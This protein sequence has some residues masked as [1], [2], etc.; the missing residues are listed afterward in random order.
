MIRRLFTLLSALSLLLCVGTCVLWARAWFQPQPPD[1]EVRWGDASKSSRWTVGWIVGFDNYLF[2]E[3][4]SPFRPLPPERPHE[5]V[6]Y[7]SISKW[8][9][10]G[11]YYS[12]D[13]V[14]RVRRHTPTSETFAERSQVWIAAVWPASLTAV[15]PILSLFRF[16]RRR[17]HRTPGACT[18][19]GYDLRA[20]PDR[21]PECGA[22]PPIGKVK[23]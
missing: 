19:C 13:Q 21:C 16:A 4:Y 23:A 22:V 9:R 20:T 3:R 11:F 8:G 18:E 10:F 14:V 15:L 7:D 5:Y 12:R 17:L 1:I 2:I 6:F